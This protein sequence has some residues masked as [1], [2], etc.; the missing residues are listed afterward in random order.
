MAVDRWFV[1]RARIER[2][3]ATGTDPYGHPLPSVWTE[4]IT[5]L[6][7]FFYERSGPG[8]TTAG[9]KTAV[10][11]MPEM[12]VADDADVT[13]GD[14]VNGITDRLGRTIDDS[15]MDIKAVLPR[16]THKRVLLEVVR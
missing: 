16:A 14:R 13:E 11:V 9:G 3:R 12:L 2:N 8:E 6:P 15:L 4:H 7:C 1:H 10:V 5:T